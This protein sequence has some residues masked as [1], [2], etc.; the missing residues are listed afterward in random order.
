MSDPTNSA[1][2]NQR[3]SAAHAS[4]RWK[5]NISTLCREYTKDAVLTLVEIMTDPNQRA[6]DRVRAANSIL[7]RGWGTAPVNIK[8][9]ADGMTDLSKMGEAE[10][11]AIIAENS[12][13]MNDVADGEFVD[14]YEAEF[15]D[16]GDEVDLDAP[17][18]K[19]GKK[20]H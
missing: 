20:V 19:T 13:L 12:A 10:L 7:D 2:Y 4:K 16:E 1:T 6:G 15:T 5:R 18:Q 14:D 8:V 11:L 9:N 3:K 17:E